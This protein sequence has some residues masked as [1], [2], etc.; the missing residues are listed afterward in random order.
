MTRH[1]NR[2]PKQTEVV[3]ADKGDIKPKLVRRTRDSHSRYNSYNHV[4]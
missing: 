2:M 3:I 4:H 1:T